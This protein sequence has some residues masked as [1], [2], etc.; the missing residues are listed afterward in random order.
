M[1]PYW[2]IYILPALMAA[3]HRRPAVSL[4]IVLGAVYALLIGLRYQVGG[5][6]SSYQLHLLRVGGLPLHQV[7][8]SSDP[9]YYALTWLSSRIGAGIWFVNL[10]CGLIFTTGLVAFVRRLP[11]PMLAFA[12]AMPYM[13]VVVAMGY[14][15]QATALGFL[16][17]GLAW[18]IERRLLAFAL[19]L[20][21]GATFH[22]SAVV[23]LPLA[24]LADQRTRFL[25]VLWVGIATTVLYLLF[26]AEQVDSFWQNYVLSDYSQASDGGPIRI[27][28]NVLPAVLF[29]LWRRRFVMTGEARALWTWVAL[30]SLA[31]LPLVFQAPTAVDR[32]ALYF[33]PLQL[34]LFSHLP[35][36]VVPAQRAYVRGAILA[37]YAA[38]LFVWLNFAGH[39][40]AWLPYQFWPL[41]AG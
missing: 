1:F 18:L 33:M 28:M 5:D 37:Y 38:V 22:K 19:A 24:I 12:V 36:L 14:T 11:E 17:F 31:C 26:L 21:V 41:A 13:L 39:R 35:S 27:A 7:L 32:I 2:G 23:L 8:I 25:T 40:Q 30:F 15:R 3:T 29:L 20:A 34:V 4:W 16:L 9:G 10:V 6:W